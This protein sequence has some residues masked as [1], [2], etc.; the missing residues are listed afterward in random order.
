MLKITLGP[1]FVFS[2]TAIA[3][4]GAP[5]DDNA[6]SAALS[7]TGLPI[8]APGRSEDVVEAEGRAIA[9]LS[10]RGYADARTTPREVVWP[11]SA[12]LAA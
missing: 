11:S 8:G 2:D 9:A 10:A 12:G 5:P 6:R 1:R 7:V 3:W 4:Q